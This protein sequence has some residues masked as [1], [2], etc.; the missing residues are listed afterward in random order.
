M[1]KNKT[2]LKKLLVHFRKFFR[3]FNK[4][5]KR[6]AYGL[7]VSPKHKKESFWDKLLLSIL[8]I[9]I[10]VVF[11]YGFPFLYY[12]KNTDKIKIKNEAKKQIAITQSR[13]NP[14][15]E[16]KRKLKVIRKTVDRIRPS[17]SDAKF[18]LQLGGS[19]TGIGLESQNIENIVFKE[20]EVDKPARIVYSLQATYPPS[21]E[22][23]G[24]SG[25]VELYIVIDENGDI[26]K[27]EVAKETPQGYGFKEACLEVIY[28]FKFRPAMKK[29]IPV[30]MEYI[31]PFNF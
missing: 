22:E 8:A 15:Q 3:K 6:R 18:K 24:I 25:E 14:K 31:Y 1:R 21:A 17:R 4:R 5:L 10:T 9:C 28:Q 2:S 12:L 13:P 23:S 7:V 19:G 30:K 26:I 16:K 11:T 27:A 20:G 29:N